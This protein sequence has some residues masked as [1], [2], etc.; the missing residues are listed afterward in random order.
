MANVLNEIL[1]KV[2][3]VK[4][5][6]GFLDV[7]FRN[8]KNIVLEGADVVLF[9]AGALG[10]EMLY[11]LNRN[12]IKPVCFCDNDTQK[13]G[14]TIEGLPVISFEELV[15]QHKSS[16]IVLS[17][18]H[19]SDLITKQLF[20]HDFEL[21]RVFRKESEPDSKL[22]AMYSMV[23]SQSLHQGYKDSVASGVII[24][25]LREIADKVQQAHDSY[26]D[27]KSKQLFILK[28]A[29]F[30]SDLH[31]ALF[32][33]FMMQFSEPVLQ[34]GVLAYQ[35]TPEDYFYF[36]NDVLQVEE[37]DIYVDVGAF[38]GDSIETFVEACSNAEVKYQHIYGIEPDPECFVK[39]Q[40]NCQKIDNISLHQ[41]GLWSSTQ[42]LHFEPSSMA[43]H[44]QAGTIID[45]G[46]IK[47]KALQLDDFLQNKKVTFIKMDPSCDVEE[48]M[49]GALKTLSTYKPKLALGI[50][51]SLDEF[52]NIPILLKKTVPEYQLFLRHN[53]YHLCDTDL[54]GH[55]Y[56]K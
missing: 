32:K 36:N 17:L 30:A 15:E 7:L 5:T 11:A 25:R 12:G 13:H 47:I 18:T 26:D 39:L 31:F 34:F 3:S 46:G 28:L 29:V 42:T 37:G 54:Y 45:E 10:K 51:H 14:K 55:V 50:Y 40:H 33:Q 23:G 16:F 21:E 48:V 27:E 8:Y 43:I 9:G 20:L 4:H 49:K 6:A 24:N 38:D 22:L 35:G 19:G 53:T 2:N 41:I 56:I 1:E 52:I 44:E